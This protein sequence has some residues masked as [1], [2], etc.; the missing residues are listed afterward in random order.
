MRRVLR[1]IIVS[2]IL[3]I[4][5]SCAQ[6]VPLTG[7]QRDFVPPKLV[8]SVPDTNAIRF[9]SE[10]IELSFNE[11]V[12][13][14]N[15]NSQ[16]IV[17][18]KLKTL[19]EITT[20]G[21]K[22]IIKLKKE[23]LK[24][25]TTYRISFGRAIADM[26]ES[27]SING[28]DYVFSTGDFIDSIKIRGTV[29]DAFN[30]KPSSYILIGLYPN[31][32]E[33]DS[34]VFQKEA[35]YISRSG[36]DGQ[37]DFKNL[38]HET[39]RLYAFW[40]KNK[41]GTYDGETEK[42]AFYPSPLKLESDT[43]VQLKLFQEVSPRAYIKKV[44]N[45]YYGFSQLL[46]NKKTKIELLTLNG[47]DQEKITEV[48]KGIEKDTVS[49]YYKDVQDSLKISL[50]ISGSEKIDTIK[51][52][53]P[54]IPTNTRKRLKTISSNVSSGSLGIMGK[55]QINFPTWMDTVTK[56]LS[57]IHITSKEDSLVVLKTIKGHWKTV[58]SFEIDNIFKEG[59]AYT[60]RIDTNAFF[61]V[62]QVSNDSAIFNFKAKARSDFGKLTL[63]ILVTKKRPY[64]LQLINEREEV[65]RE[66]SFAP[67][68]SSTNVVSIDFTELPPG[69]YLAK[70][71]FD[72]NENKKW[73]SGD[74]MKQQQ[75]EKV[76]I[77]SKQ[78]KV[79][80]DWEVEEEVLFKE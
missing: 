31:S 45:P 60:L 14:K 5:W 32:K 3:L 36:E 9:N 71:I 78:L 50:K 11:Y 17:S 59:T 53:L 47:S 30:N 18:P 4:L 51:L 35:D 58:N 40:D 25:N 24:P 63:K 48:N 43:S 6:I 65:I 42:I 44:S 67:S 22:V 1:Y 37:F 73:D 27:N 46:L 76:I 69:I 57:R 39:F 75:P 52:K 7:G 20:E 26:N 2:A 72:D 66:S 41:N 8:S 10:T 80:S 54:K 79:I 28:F 33:T 56:D 16:L 77:H 49:F 15:L 74:F 55:V 64:L 23:E 21:K 70:L 38:P 29:T 62:K 12:Q 34:T 13:L 68:L 19:P 61:D